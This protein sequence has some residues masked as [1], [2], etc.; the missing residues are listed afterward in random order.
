M[1]AILESKNFF[2]SSLNEIGLTQKR[3]EKYLF[4]YATYPL[5]ILSKPKITVS[6]REEGKLLDVI[7]RDLVELA[8]AGKLDPL[9][10]REKELSD[11]IKILSRRKKNNPII[12]GDAGVGKTVLVEGLAQRIADGRVPSLLRD[13]RI[14]SVDVA[15]I[16]AGS[17]M[18]GDIEEKVLEMVD[19]VVESN[20]IILFIDE[21]HNIFTSGIP[22]TP[23][24]IGSILKP[25][26]LKEDF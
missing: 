2:T 16:M 20:N 14:I 25:A 19:E 24:E 9:V 6:G 3:F 21:I 1:L 13:M 23:S 11:I 8:R 10:G 22:G 15:S 26:L 7:G 4:E 18:R 5:G 17:R 12:V